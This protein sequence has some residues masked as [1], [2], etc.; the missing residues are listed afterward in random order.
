MTKKEG[1]LVLL[2]LVLLTVYVIWFTD[3]FKPRIIHISH[4]M[5]PMPQAR[6]ISRDIGVVVSFGFDHPLRFKEI[7]VVPRE[8]WLTNPFTAP[9]WHLVSD[10]NSVPVG[11][12]VY[13]RPVRGMR[14]ARKGI[15]PEPLVTNTVY[16][17]LVTAGKVTGQHD[18]SIGRPLPV[19]K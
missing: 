12:V 13:G 19:A 8:S 11:F 15:G 2:T 16:R 6:R 14:P 1:M 10:S 18:F 5:R 7:S 3:W 9:L 4:T 17:L